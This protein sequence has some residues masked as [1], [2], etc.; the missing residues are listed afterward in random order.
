MKPNQT[1]REFLL[2]STALAL[3][4]FFGSREPLHAQSSSSFDTPV[5][6]PPEDG[7]T[8]VDGVREFTLSLQSGKTEF[9]EGVQTDTMGING[10]YLGPVLRMRTGETV[11]FDVTNTL[12]IE[13]TLHWHGL[14]LPASTD[15][16]PH[17]PIEPGGTWSPSFKIHDVAS[18]MWY[19]SHQLH[20]TASQVWA[21]LAGMIIIDDE[22]SDDLDIPSTY[23]VDDIPLVLQDRRFNRDGSMPYEA[24]MHDEMAGMS[25]NVPLI[26]GTVR[27]Y[28]DVSTEKLRLRLLNGANASIYNLAFSDGR[29][30]VQIASD[31]GF[32]G[33]PAEMSELLLAPG[34][35]AEIIVDFTQNE[36]VILES[37]ALGGRRGGGQGMGMGGGMMMAEQNPQFQL[38]EFRAA[39]TL[40]PLAEVPDKL[41]ELPR[42]SE[43]QATKTREFL[44]EMPGMGPL[45]M[46]GMGGGFTINGNAM[47]MRRVDE[48]VKLGETEIWEIVNAGPMIHP[49]HIHNTQFRL[50]DRDGLLPGPNEA[51]LKDTVVVFPGERVRLLVRFDH[52]TDPERPY[53]Y[54]CHILEHE[55]AGMMGQFTVV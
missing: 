17:Q 26:N 42:I 22:V 40:E 8:L 50:L 32:L 21:G 4:L 24:S 49:F 41:A 33:Q 12:A 13:S 35:R 55:D 51:G 39:D 54:H 19:H 2:G 48:V 5:A 16:G 1:R 38:V 7:G 43:T 27:P 34:E 45:R 20:Q 53:M 6:I 31:G 10:S 29:S 3:T 18:T 25:G 14:N 23:G 11:R 15:G 52:Y 37:K 44:L 28:V 36:R 9:F 46:L 47:K 30:F